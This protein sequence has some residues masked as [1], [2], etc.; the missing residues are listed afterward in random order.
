MNND[1][2]PS[3]WE[4]GFAKEYDGVNYSRSLSGLVLARSHLLI[5]KSFGT[6]VMIPRVLEVGAGSGVHLKYVRHN[7]NQYFMT[8]SSNEML[9]A[10]SPIDDDRVIIAQ[11]DAAN[12]SFEDSSFDRLIATHVLEH[13]H[14]PDDVLREWRRVVKPGGIISLVLPCDPGMMWR[15]GR[16]CGPR[17]KARERGVPYDYIMALEHVNSITNLSAMIDFHF[18][19]KVQYWWPTRIPS[20]DLNLIYATNIKA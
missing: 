14:R 1:K 7:F 13:L 17:R 3:I 2:N 12:L 19:D 9:S 16:A 20:V 18:N 8:D 4:S 15:L 11:E 10:I 5:E 6:D